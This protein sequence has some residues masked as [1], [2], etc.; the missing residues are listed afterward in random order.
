MEQNE[1]LHGHIQP[2]MMDRAQP[3]EIVAEFTLPDYR[4]EI[5]RLL[6][7]RPTLLPPERFI[8]GGKA[9]FSGAVLFE[10]LYTGPDGVLYGTEL[11]GG[12]T[13]GVP[14][15]GLGSSE[16][17]QIFADPVVDAVISRVT[18]PRKLSVRCRAHTRVR[19]YV[20]KSME[21]EQKGAPEGAQPSLLCDTVQVGR[22]I[23]DG[24][25]ELTLADAVDAQEDVRVICARGSVFLPDVHA[26]KDEVA[27]R[28][29]VQL[30]LLLCRDDEENALPFTLT[31][32]VPF[33]AHIPL[34]GVC[35]EH[36]ACA[37]G[38]V[39]RIE[40]SVEDGKILLAPQLILTAK[41]QYEEPITVCRDIFLPAHSEEKRMRTEPLWRDGGCCNRNFTISCERP[42]SELDFG[43]ELEIIDLFSEADICEKAQD[44]TRFLLSGKLQCHLLCRRGD[45]LCVKDVTFP[46]RLSPELGGEQMSVDCHVFSC[47]MSVRGG[48]LRADAEL[49]LAMRHT[50]PHATALVCEVGFT[51][52][53]ARERANI[54]L[55][56]PAPAQTL[57]DVAKHY[58]IPPAQLAEANGLADCAPDAPCAKSF[59]FIP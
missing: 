6:W 27:C 12:Y 10:V 31:R 13:F 20:E 23:G 54:E 37:T 40:C 43:E 46:F 16:D 39:G 45:E 26:A 55:Y 56:Y 15:E 21:L 49:Q 53:S 51:P 59:L 41:A 32:R 17:I 8:G 42:L 9:E 28:G 34:E 57:W 48:A 19:A 3:F 1:I 58:G 22:V 24:R 52:I 44:G 47:R 18:G 5:S 25:E 30:T 14:L 35:P 38:T 33:E 50:L 2:E 4:S 11:D 7:V 29:E 36:H